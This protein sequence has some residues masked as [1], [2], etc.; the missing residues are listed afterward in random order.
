MG[1]KGDIRVF[2]M[3]ACM[4]N[5]DGGVVQMGIHATPAM[6]SPPVRGA[7]RL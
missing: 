2:F 7:S 3:D 4:Y 5:M 6:L 1:R